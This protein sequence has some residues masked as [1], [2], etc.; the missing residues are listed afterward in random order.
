LSSQSIICGNVAREEWWQQDR[1]SFGEGR[2][3]QVKRLRSKPQ[4]NSMKEDLVLLKSERL[5]PLASERPG[6]FLP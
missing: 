2:E 5:L 4:F 1:V 6:L 3:R